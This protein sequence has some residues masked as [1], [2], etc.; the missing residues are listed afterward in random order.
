MSDNNGSSPSSITSPSTILQPK[1]ESTSKS[2]IF[3]V[4]ILSEAGKPIYCYSRRQDAVTLMGVCT[5]LINYVERIQNDQLK[6]ITTTNGLKITFATKSPLIIVVLTQENSGIDSSIVICQ[7]NAKLMSILTGKT[8]K[9]VFEQRPTFD[10]KRLLTG[11]EKL[12]DTLI[13]VIT[14]PIQSSFDSDQT[15]NKPC[16]GVRAFLTSPISSTRSLTSNQSIISR[17]TINRICIPILLLSSSVRDSITNIINSCVTSSSHVIFTVLFSI[18]SNQANLITVCNHNPKIKIN[19][20]DIQII[21]S[22]V[23]ASESQLASVESFW[24]PLCLPRFDSTAFLH[25]HISYLN[26]EFCLALITSD[27]E[28]FH[29]CQLIKDAIMDRLA[30]IHLNSNTIHLSDLSNPQLQFLW[31]Q[32]HRQTVVMQQSIVC[33]FNNIIHYIVDRMLTSKLKTFWLR[34]ESDGV[35]LGW[36][37][38]SFQLYAQFDVTITQLQALTAIQSIVK[39]IKKEEDKFI[40]KDY[41]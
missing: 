32:S 37:S 1:P 18:K 19:P 24:L 11:S 2:S 36:H 5:A 33:Q 3:D 16:Q 21:Y 38:P 34:T 39:W 22:L 26:N 10:L 9:S 35:I 27:R 30:K 31:Y 14:T 6:F 8:L 29:K 40:I 23:I 4:F 12:I 41:Q 7:V 20:L 25:S 15:T 17:S 28:N 13:D